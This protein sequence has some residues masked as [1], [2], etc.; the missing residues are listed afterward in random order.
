VAATASR[1]SGEGNRL[2]AKLPSLERSPAAYTPRSLRALRAVVCRPCGVLALWHISGASRMVLV[3]G[4][5]V[6]LVLAPA[7]P[8]ASPLRGIGPALVCPSA[9]KGLPQ[10]R[11]HWIVTFVSTTAKG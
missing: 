8:M 10:T 7:H 6:Q 4:F 11:A 2:D 1:P 9:P 3:G 5:A